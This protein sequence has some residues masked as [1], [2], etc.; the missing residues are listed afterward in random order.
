M[1]IADTAVL[2]RMLE[3]LAHSLTPDAARSIAEFHADAHVQAYIDELAAK[4]NE[5]LLTPEERR[6][7]EAY[8]EAI[9]II[10]IFQ[11]KARQ[12]LEGNPE[13]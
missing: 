3:P 13:A 7:Y 12:A 6:E 5:G 9:D 4:C 11:E 1:D 10:A 8:V 2:D